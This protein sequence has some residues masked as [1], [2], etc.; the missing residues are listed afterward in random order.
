MQA[1][2]ALMADRREVLLAERTAL[3][4][5]D[6]KEK[7][8]RKT[9]AAVKAAAALDDDFEIPDDIELQPEHEVLQ[10]DLTDARKDLL[11]DME[12]RAVRSIVVELAGIAAKISRDD[13]PEKIMAKEGANALRRLISSQS[14]YPASFLRAVC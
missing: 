11:E 7:K 1:Y 9:R 8:L 6:V 12:N 5:H 4:A 3:A 10:R 14:L 2:A 13:D